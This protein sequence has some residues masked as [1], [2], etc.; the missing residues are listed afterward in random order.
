[1]K[2]K[3]GLTALLLVLLLAGGGY[4]LYRHWLPAWGQRE[5][6]AP[7]REFFQVVFWDSA[8]KEH[9][10]QEFRQQSFLV[11]NFWA[12]W[13]LPC[14]EALP[15]IARAQQRWQK[16]SVDFVGV[17]VDTPAHMASFMQH[18]APFVYPVVMGEEAG[19]V[20]LP[21]LGNA[22]RT[23][24]YT[25]VIDHNGMI[26]YRKLGP[27]SAKQLDEVLNSLRFGTL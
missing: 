25:V 17:A 12:T 2:L 16:Q 5:T 7:P 11:V 27:I 21:L 10:L 3:T 22:S 18:Q 9:V 8:G 13:C 6:L 4:I 26:R 23:L 20:L 15:E 14:R 24:P 19:L 1:M